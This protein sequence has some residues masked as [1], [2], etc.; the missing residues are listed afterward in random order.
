MNFPNR[1]LTD[2]IHVNKW[3]FHGSK[4]LVG[5]DWNMTG[6]F[7][8]YTGNFIIPFDSYFSEGFKY[9]QPDS[10]LYL[11]QELNHIHFHKLP[12]G[13]SFYYPFIVKLGM[14]S[15]WLCPT[16]CYPTAC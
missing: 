5:G 11:L 2:G 12:M 10:I 15:Y 9:D 4:F 1:A 16:T 6:L 8:P 13:D 7:S 3:K 14:V